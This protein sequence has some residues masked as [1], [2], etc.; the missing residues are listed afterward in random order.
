MSHKFLAA[1]GL[2]GV[3]AL[4][5]HSKAASAAIL[6]QGTNNGTAGGGVCLDVAYDS[7]TAGTKV[8]PVTCSA[9]A[10]EQL[11]WIGETIYLIG[12][13]R[14]LDTVGSSTAAGSAIASNVCSN[15]ATQHWYLFD[16]QVVNLGVG[17]CLDTSNAVNGGAQ[18][19]L[20]NCN[21]AVSQNW[22]VK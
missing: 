13:Q 12:G 4:V 21:G 9:D 18:L 5:G 6:T 11:E 8:G 14:C 7:I 2:F 10:A 3:L 1:A 19:H 16:G 20:E 17:Q 15:S 22:Q